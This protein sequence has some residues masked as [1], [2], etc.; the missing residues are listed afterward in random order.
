MRYGL[1]LEEY[2]VSIDGMYGFPFNLLELL[3]LDAFHFP[4]IGLLSLLFALS[5]F[6][7]ALNDFFEL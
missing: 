4:R 3:F 6:V 5:L 2:T 1:R 7:S